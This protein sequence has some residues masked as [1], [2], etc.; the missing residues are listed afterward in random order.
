MRELRPGQTERVVELEVLRR[1]G[2]PFLRVSSMSVLP[3]R[4]TRKVTYLAAQD[5]RD[6]HLVVV[7]DVGKVVRREPVRLA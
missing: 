5:V 2:K 4:E 1:R 7:D 3:Q 6:A